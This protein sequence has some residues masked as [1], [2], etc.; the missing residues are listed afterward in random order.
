MSDPNLLT[1]RQVQALE[2]T[3]ERL[4]KADVSALY[5]PWTQRT[6]NP[7]ALVASPA[8]WGD[9]GVPWS[10]NVLAFYSSVFVNT[11]NNG[12]NFWTIELL[13]TPSATTIASFTTAAISANIFTRLSTTTITQPASS[14]ADLFIRATA[15]LAPGSI[16]I[17]PAVALLRTGN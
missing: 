17:A 6:L 3:Q 7:I 11:T 1:Q 10:V 13:A 8:I 12:T 9:M 2:I 15:T 16:F 5:L 14:D 4:R